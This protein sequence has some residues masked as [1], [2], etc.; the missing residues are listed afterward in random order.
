MATVEL[1][2]DKVPDRKRQCRILFTSRK[3]PP[4]PCCF[5]A[6][7]LGGFLN[8][9]DIIAGPLLGRGGGYLVVTCF[10]NFLNLTLD[11]TNK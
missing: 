8:Y 9:I 2:S 3:L 7:S 1:C 6:N 10:V 11:D 4:A 5:R